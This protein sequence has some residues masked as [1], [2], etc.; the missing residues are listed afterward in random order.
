M[1]GQIHYPSFEVQ[2][3]QQQVTHEKPPAIDDGYS[4]AKT[5]PFYLQ[6]VFL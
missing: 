5:V 3:L 1:I 2:P 4:I 6:L